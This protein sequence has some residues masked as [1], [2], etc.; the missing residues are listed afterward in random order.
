M[1]TSQKEIEE[2]NNLINKSNEIKDS[3]DK[4][5]DCLL[6][7][8]NRSAKAEEKNDGEKI[9]NVYMKSNSMVLK[10]SANINIIKANFNIVQ[11]QPINTFQFSKSKSLRVKNDFNRNNL[12]LNNLQGHL[13]TV[14][15]TISEVSNSKKSKEM[16]KNKE[17][18]SKFCNN[19]ENSEKIVDS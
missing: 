17:T 2:N 18:K 13:E 8:D 11:E 15:E 6:E 14:I 12:N 1:S 16:S 3:V 10:P 5:L 4:R 9:N 7:K 19:N